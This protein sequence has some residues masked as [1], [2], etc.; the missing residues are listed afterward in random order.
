MDDLEVLSVKEQ[1]VW[2][3]GKAGTRIQVPESRKRGRL[4]TSDNGMV[5]K[6]SEGGY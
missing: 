2:R 6:G 4:G 1:G 3:L 5:R